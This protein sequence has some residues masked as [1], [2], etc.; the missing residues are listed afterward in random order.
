[1]RLLFL[2][3]V[4]CFPQPRSSVAKRVPNPRSFDAED[5]VDARARQRQIGIGLHRVFDPVTEEETPSL[6]L[7]LLNQ[8]D[9]RAAPP[10][11][12][13]AVRAKRRS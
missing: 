3:R 5:V 4:S 1:M 6:F 7:D 2:A 13:N 10:A 8:A 9:Q 12:P 11:A